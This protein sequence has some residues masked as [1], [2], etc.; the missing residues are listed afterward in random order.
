MKS[1]EATRAGVSLASLP[2]MNMQ[3]KSRKSRTK[4]LARAGR[5]RRAS[6]RARE[7]SAARTAMMR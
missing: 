1:G 4:E 2:S 5:T 7:C 3:R 6:L